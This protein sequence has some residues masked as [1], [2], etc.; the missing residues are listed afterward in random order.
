MTLRLDSLSVEPRPADTAEKPA[1][2]AWGGRVGDVGVEALRVTSGGDRAAELTGIVDYIV[3]RIPAAGIRAGATWADSGSGTVRMDIFG[4]SEHRRGEWN[5]LA[6]VE[7]DGSRVVPVRLRETFEQLGDGNQNGVKIT[8]TSQGRRSGTYYV[9]M[10][11]RVVGAELSDSL[12]MLISVPAR[13]Q[14]VPTT[15]ISHTTIRFLP[16]PRARA[17]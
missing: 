6:A 11:G 5:A 1:N 7:R 9:T 13:K 10:D 14:V 8:M 4:T 3:P 16:A 2:A 17:S 15:R 12:S